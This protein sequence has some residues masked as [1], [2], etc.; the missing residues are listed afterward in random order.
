MKN[1]L[2]TLD[3]VVPIFNE[4]ECLDILLERLISLREEIS[5]KL[6]ASLVT[7]E[8]AFLNNQMRVCTNNTVSKF[9]FKSNHDCLNNN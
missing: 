3:I 1:N 2:P 6:D 9:F 5:S 7:F 4:I 8:K